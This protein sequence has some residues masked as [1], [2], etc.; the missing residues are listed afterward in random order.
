MVSCVAVKRARRN[1]TVMAKAYSHP[2][3]R[4]WRKL[5]Q[6]QKKITPIG[7]IHYSTRTCFITPRHCR[8]NAP[9]GQ[10]NKK[11]CLTTRTHLFDGRRRAP[12]GS[13]N[14]SRPLEHDVSSLPQDRRPSTNKVTGPATVTRVSPKPDG[15][16]HVTAHMRE[17]RGRPRVGVRYRSSS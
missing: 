13:G 14:K 15:Q 12:R 4:R 3:S 5:E 10:C 7:L 8:S 11:Y 6:I 16:L 1:F 17:V 9:G 2:T